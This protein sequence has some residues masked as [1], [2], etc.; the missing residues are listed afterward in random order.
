MKIISV[1]FD[2]FHAGRRKNRH[3]EANSRVR[4]L[5]N[6]PRSQSINRIFQQLK[7][8]LY[9]YLFIFIFFAIF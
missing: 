4:N 5:D 8:T 9:I 2:S 7:R 1:K 6:V 3:G